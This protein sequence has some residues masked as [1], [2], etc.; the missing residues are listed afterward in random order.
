MSAHPFAVGDT[1]TMLPHLPFPRADGFEPPEMP[2]VG[3][4]YTVARV[5]YLTKDRCYPGEWPIILLKEIEAGP[6][7]VWAADYFIRVCE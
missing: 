6:E 7:V 2:R 5:G 3:R 4:C 1:V